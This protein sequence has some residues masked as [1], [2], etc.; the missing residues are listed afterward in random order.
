MALLQRGRCWSAHWT[1]D[2]HAERPNRSRSR[3]PLERLLRLLAPSPTSDL[4]KFLRGEISAG[5]PASDLHC[6]PR[7]RKQTL[8]PLDGVVY[9]LIRGSQFVHKPA[10]RGFGRGYEKSAHGEAVGVA[11]ADEAAATLLGSP[12]ATGA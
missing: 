10:G 9:N 7:K 1:P 3:L 5:L 6:R 12:V 2:I 4:G 8:A 11:R